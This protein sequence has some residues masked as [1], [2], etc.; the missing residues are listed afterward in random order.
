MIQDN[1]TLHGRF[2]TNFLISPTYPLD[3]LL[4][5]EFAIPGPFYDPDSQV[6]KHL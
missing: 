5:I 3:S 6:N 1:K 2:V 4:S